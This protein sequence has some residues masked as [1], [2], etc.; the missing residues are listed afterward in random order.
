MFRSRKYW[1]DYFC[2][3][4]GFF[5]FMHEI[6]DK[7]PMFTD[8]NPKHVVKIDTFCVCETKHDCH[9]DST[10][11]SV[12]LAVGLSKLR[13]EAFFFFFKVNW[14]ICIQCMTANIFNHCH[15]IWRSI[16]RLSFIIAMYFNIKKLKSFNGHCGL[17]D[18]KISWPREIFHSIGYRATVKVEHCVLHNIVAKLALIIVFLCSV[19]KLCNFTETVLKCFYQFRNL[20][21]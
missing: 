6:N 11:I 13:F 12:F 7:M 8:T 19:W 2:E 4:L 18:F 15:W 5:G 1:N 9:L 14:L 16:A 17:Q 3:L 10:S 21:Y 20:G